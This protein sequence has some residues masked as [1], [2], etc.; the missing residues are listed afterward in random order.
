MT[1][2]NEHPYFGSGLFFK[3]SLSV[4]AKDKVALANLLNTHEFS[5]QDAQPFIGSWCTGVADTH[6]V[7]VS[8]FPNHIYHPKIVLIIIMWMNFRIK[9]A[10]SFLHENKS[11]I[12]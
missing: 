7:F 11:L 9:I 1:D 8:F 10:K 5:L 12:S 3:L 2:S 4:N 6:M